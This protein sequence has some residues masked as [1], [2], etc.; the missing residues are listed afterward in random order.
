MLPNFYKSM[1]H[2]KLTWSFSYFVFR[3]FGIQN[4]TEPFLFLPFQSI[5]R[6]YLVICLYQSV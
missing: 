2:I 3:I 6:L 1:S 4:L 5:V